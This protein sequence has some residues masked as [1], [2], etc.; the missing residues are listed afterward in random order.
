[1]DSIQSPTGAIPSPITN[2]PWEARLKIFERLLDPPVDAPPQSE[3]LMKAPAQSRTSILYNFSTDYILR[4]QYRDRWN[5]VKIGKLLEDL[6]ALAGTI[7]V[8]IVEELM[9]ASILAASNLAESGIHLAWYPVCRYI[10]HCSVDE[11]MIRPVSFVTASVNRMVLKK[12]ISVDIDTKISGAVI[13]VGRSLIEIHWKSIS[14]PPKVT[15][16]CNLSWFVGHELVEQKLQNPNY[17]SESRKTRTAE[18]SSATYT[19]VLTA[20]FIF[21]AQDSDWEGCSGRRDRTGEIEN[22]DVSR[23]K[24]MLAEGWIFC[25]MPALADR[26]SILLRDTRLENSLICQPWQRNIHGHIFGGFLMHRAFEPAFSTAGMMPSFLEVDHVDFLRP[27]LNTFNFTFSV[28]PEA[29]PNKNGFRI[30][31]VVPA[32]E[33]EARRV[34]ECMEAENYRLGMPY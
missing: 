34:P 7:S 18:N 24:A 9:R 22:G 14:P 2:A 11:S 17:K 25:D 29:A 30:R 33:E 31:N 23:L 20:N 19:V 8:K 26:D 4:E 3:L 21:V 1:M 32:A 5:G 28:C 12:P 13:W 15:W 16:F 27:V 10:V 6:D